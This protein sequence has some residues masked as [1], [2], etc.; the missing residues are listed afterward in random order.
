MTGDDEQL[1]VSAIGLVRKL[2]R[3]LAKQCHSQGIAAEDVAIGA[4]FATFDVAH[5]FNGDHGAVEW[6]RTGAD[7]IERQLLRQAKHC[8]DR[9]ADEAGQ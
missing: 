8:S 1:S 3:N 5:T 7:L 9:A 2:A 4:L 6:L